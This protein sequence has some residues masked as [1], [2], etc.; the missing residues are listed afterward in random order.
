VHAK[1]NKKSHQSKNFIMFD[2]QTTALLLLD[3]CLLTTSTI[4]ITLS[5][6]HDGFILYSISGAVLISEILKFFVSLSCWFIYKFKNQESLNI[7]KELSFQESVHFI[8]PSILFAIS[9][10]L[11]YQCLQFLPP[12]V[13]QIL[14][15]LRIIVTILT[16][17]FI[18]SK[19]ISMIQ[20][21][22]IIILMCSVGLSRIQLQVG[23]FDLTSQKFI[24]GLVLMAMMIIST[25]FSNV[26]FEYLSKKNFSTSIFIQNLYLFSGGII[27]NFFLSFMVHPS[28]ITIFE[29]FNFFTILS[30]VV[31]SILGIVS[32]CVFKFVNNIFHVFVSTLSVIGV[33]MV[34]FILFGVR[35][36]PHFFIS[37]ILIFSSLYIYSL[38]ENANPIDITKIYTYERVAQNEEEIAKIDKTEEISEK[39]EDFT[40]NNQLEELTI[41]EDV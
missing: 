39:I 40:E 17:K 35:I 33:A 20:T 6:T 8:I 22:S 23:W 21:F 11:I 4:T 3:L 28:L 1:E 2:T 32:L 15:N 24:F 25:S 27:V 31:S 37:I 9:N 5:Q 7:F 29:N 26:Y 19:N 12:Q 30:I 16:F 18:F 10:N 38:E 36:T 14:L 34:D 41:V 13:Y